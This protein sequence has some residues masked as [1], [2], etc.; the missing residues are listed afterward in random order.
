MG[1]IDNDRVVGEK[2]RVV[3]DLHEEDPIG[4]NLHKGIARG[5]V[6]KT[7]LVADR[8]SELF[9]ISSAIRRATVVAAMRLGWVQR[10]GLPARGPLPDTSSGSVWSSRAGFSGHDNDGMFPDGGNDILP[11]LQD[12]QG[13]RIENPGRQARRVAIFFIV[14]SDLVKGLPFHYVHMWTGKQ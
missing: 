9:P 8:P 5:P 6:V 10:S 2:Q 13:R 1:F 4:H 11:S 3:M 7:D 14:P 12:R